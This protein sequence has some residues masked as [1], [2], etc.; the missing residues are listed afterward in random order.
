MRKKPKKGSLKSLSSKSKNTGFHTFGAEPSR[1]L[2]PTR[3]GP[4]INRR[5]LSGVIA[6]VQATSQEIIAP[7]VGETPLR[8]L[9][10]LALSSDGVEISETEKKAR[11]NLAV[12][13]GSGILIKACPEPAEG[14]DV[15]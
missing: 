15:P 2:F 6:K 5:A 7:Y 4:L 3:K 11:K 14:M 1:G 9:Q 8:Q 12:A 13:S 10:E